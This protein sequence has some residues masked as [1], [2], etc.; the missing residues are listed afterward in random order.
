MTWAVSIETVTMTPPTDD[1]VDAVVDALRNY[2][3]AVSISEDRI[4]CTLTTT[5][6]NTLDAGERAT[7]I[8]RDRLLDVGI[9]PG[10]DVGLEII[11]TDEQDCRVGS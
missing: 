2:G 8:W 7:T 4:G 1:Q 11:T 3:G 10:V 5:G 9:V 6:A